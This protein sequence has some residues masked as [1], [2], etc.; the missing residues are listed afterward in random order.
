[1]YQTKCYSTWLSFWLS[2]LKSPCV[3]HDEAVHDQVKY[4]AK[5]HR[6]MFKK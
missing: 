5:I 4:D 6:Y 3:K 1:M 2:I